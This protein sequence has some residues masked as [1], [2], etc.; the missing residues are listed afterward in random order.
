MQRVS[1]LKLHES[2][3]NSGIL[4]LFIMFAFVF[5]FG[6]F[7]GFLF[8]FVFFVFLLFFCLFVCCFLFFVFFALFGDCK[9]KKLEINLWRPDINDL[10]KIKK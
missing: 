9:R 3:K 5:V 4:L 1:V 2:G 6:G 7:W 8:V 10:T